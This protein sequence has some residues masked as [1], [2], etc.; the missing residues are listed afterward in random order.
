[1]YF[2]E[3]GVNPIFCSKFKGNDFARLVRPTVRLI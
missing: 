3:N 2:N 1:M